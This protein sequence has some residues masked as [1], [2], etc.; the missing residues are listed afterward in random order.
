MPNMIDK[1]IDSNKDKFQGIYFNPET[2]YL[3]MNCS[4]EDLDFLLT[5]FIKY[6]NEKFTINGK[7]DL[8]KFYKYFDDFITS[9]FCLFTSGLIYNS[10]YKTETEKAKTETEK[11]KIEREKSIDRLLKRFFGGNN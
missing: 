3:G 8:N 5:Y 2:R 7:F 10:Q 1:M 4:N 11:A 9:F 6:L